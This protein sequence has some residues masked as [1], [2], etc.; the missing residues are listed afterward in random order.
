VDETR[1]L[2]DCDRRHQ[3]YVRSLD[4]IV[5]V[6]PDAARPSWTRKCQPAELVAA[7]NHMRLPNLNEL[8]TNG[9]ANP[10]CIK[11]ACQPRS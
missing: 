2:N 11:R 6:W 5:S 1:Y 4:T 10:S 7:L 9:R 3:D 8:V